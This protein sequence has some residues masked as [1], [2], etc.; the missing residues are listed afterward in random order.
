MTTFEK[1]QPNRVFENAGRHA[2]MLGVNIANNPYAIGNKQFRSWDYGF[3]KAS[4]VPQRPSMPMKA[5][6]ALLE[7][8][9]VSLTTY[10]QRQKSRVFDFKRRAHKPAPS[11]PIQARA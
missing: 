6:L 5:F 4:M 2:F 9:G 1:R 10:E 7:Q 3:K 11:Q 8:F